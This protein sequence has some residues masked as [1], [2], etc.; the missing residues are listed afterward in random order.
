MVTKKLMLFGLGSSIVFAVSGVGG[1]AVVNY[2]KENVKTLTEQLNEAVDLKIIPS[3]DQKL[4]FFS[5]E[6]MTSFAL[7]NDFDF[8]DVEGYN[9]NL[10]YSIVAKESIGRKLKITVE[11]SVNDSQTGNYEVILP[12]EFA[13][14]D[15]SSQSVI[16][17]T[18][19]VFPRYIDNLNVSVLPKPDTTIDPSTIVIKSPDF[20]KNA[21][22]QYIFQRNGASLLA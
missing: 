10:K 1:W 11:V 22:G 17:Q 9:K 3:I 19:E 21:S 6:W 12:E 15:V 5:S 20:H 18:I 13:T 14:P 4:T 2:Y 8:K 7:N 16:N